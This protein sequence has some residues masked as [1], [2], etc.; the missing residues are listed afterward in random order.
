MERIFK[1][2]LREIYHRSPFEN[3]TP[4]LEIR[5]YSDFTPPFPSLPEEYEKDSPV[6]WGRSDNNSFFIGP[7]VKTSFWKHVS[8]ICGANRSLTSQK[9]IDFSLL[10]LS[11]LSVFSIEAAHRYQAFE[12]EFSDYLPRDFSDLKLALRNS[13]VQD[14]FAQAGIPAE[15]IEEELRFF[16]AHCAQHSHFTHGCF[17]FRN[18]A[19]SE[20]ETL[21]ILSGDD[22]IKGS[23]LVSKAALLA[24]LFDFS[25]SQIKEAERALIVLYTEVTDKLPEAEKNILDRF[26]ALYT[27]SHHAQF[28]YSTQWSDP[29]PTLSAAAK[30]A[31]TGDRKSVV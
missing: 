21:L 19:F 11:A 26:I 13:L 20:S 17:R 23:F 2:G 5:N 1:N 15:H 28:I 22:L 7:P 16:S 31:S 3:D 4:W 12:R 18:L 25:A 29:L 6:Y 8:E 9:I 30:I 24:D 14:M 10:A 27:F